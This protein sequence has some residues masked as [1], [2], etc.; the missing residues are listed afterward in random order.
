MQFDYFL[1]ATTYFLFSTM[2]MD[3]FSNDKKAYYK[4]PVRIPTFVWTSRWP[5]ESSGPALECQPCAPQLRDS[6]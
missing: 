4:I 3:G 2:S 6:G 1:H 5:L